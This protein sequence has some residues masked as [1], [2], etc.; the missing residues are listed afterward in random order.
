MF[1]DSLTMLHSPLKAVKFV[2]SPIL[3]LG[4]AN[5]DKSFRLLIRTQESSLTVECIQ[6]ADC[7][8]FTVKIVCV[9]I[10]VE[11]KIRLLVWQHR[12]HTSS[13]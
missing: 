4:L 9:I 11:I 3:N 5:Y 8:K 1:I 7:S 12:D 13:P 6:R 10:G 2:L